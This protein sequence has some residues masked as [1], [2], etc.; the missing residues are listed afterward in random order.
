MDSYLVRRNK[1]AFNLLFYVES[2]NTFL[3]NFPIKKK[4]LFYLS[5]RSQLFIKGKMQE[6]SSCTLQQPYNNPCTKIK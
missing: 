4:I 6:T 5:C 1:K 2:Y 3:M